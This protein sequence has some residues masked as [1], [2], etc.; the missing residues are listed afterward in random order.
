MVMSIVAGTDK[1]TSGEQKPAADVFDQITEAL[2]EREGSDR[3][4]QQQPADLPVD[5]RKNDRRGERA[6]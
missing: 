1:D 2:E 4:R 6:S 3:R 5:R